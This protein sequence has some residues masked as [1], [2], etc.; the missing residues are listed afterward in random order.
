M[1]GKCGPLVVHH[2]AHQPGADCDPW[3]EGE[4]D[5]HLGWKADFL[6]AGAALEQTIERAGKRHRAD[7]VTPAGLVV[8]I[9]RRTL[10]ERALHAR[11]RFY[12]RMIWILDGTALDERFHR[13]NE[14]GHGARPPWGAGEPEHG[15]WIKQGAHRWVLHARPLFVDLGDGT[16]AHVR[17]LDLVDAAGGKRVIGGG[18]TMRRADLVD[19][20]MRLPAGTPTTKTAF[21]RPVEPHRGDDHRGADQPCTRTPC[22]CGRASYD[23]TRY[24]FCYECAQD[25]TAS[26]V[27]KL[28]RCSTCSEVGV[29]DPCR[30]CAT[31]EQL[32][33]Y[34]VLPER[35]AK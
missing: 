30:N 3:A 8:E 4:T 25:R 33:V 19:R 7:V 11:E 14:T 23:P 2:W 29:L 15:I 21:V 5:W 22:T 1:L 26:S 12:R 27:S 34:P 20:A 16:V 35:Y 32:A 6:A 31:P 9:Q 13:G 10:D 28:P 18:H 24:R 17:G